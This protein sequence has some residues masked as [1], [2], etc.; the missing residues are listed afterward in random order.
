MVSSKRQRRWD[1]DPSKHYEIQILAKDNRAIALEVS[2]KLLERAGTPACVLAIAR[3]ITARKEAEESLRQNA[4]NFEYLFSNHPMP[5]W[6]FD[7]ETLQF[8]EVNQ[9]GR[10]KHG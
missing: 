9:A 2:S 8:L 5:M 3:D 7:V 1:G 6:V 10:A 4:E